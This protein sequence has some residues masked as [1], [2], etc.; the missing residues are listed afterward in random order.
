MLPYRLLQEVFP[1]L[2]PPTK[3]GGALSLGPKSISCFS[4]FLHSFI[5]SFLPLFIQ[6][7]KIPC[8]ARSKHSKKHFLA[9]HRRCLCLSHTRVSSVRSDLL[10]HSQGQLDTQRRG[11]GREA[12]L[13][14]VIWPD[15][16]AES[17]NPE[18]KLSPFC[19]HLVPQG[20]AQEA[21]GVASAAPDKT[22]S[23]KNVL[24][25]TCP[26]SRQSH[27]RRRESARP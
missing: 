26:A 24:R 21:A 11:W 10:A 12:Y 7:K 20:T 19:S 25:N 23:L 8:L 6:K 2:S 5:H 4:S 17:R 22:R 15:I 14:G 27:V 18:F 13:A 1:F 9:Q 3:G 16:L